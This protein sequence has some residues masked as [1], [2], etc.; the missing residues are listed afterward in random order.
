[1]H[2][3]RRARGP[4][5]DPPGAAPRGALRFIEHGRSPDAKVARRQDQFDPLQG[6]L[7]GGCHLNR[8]IDDLVAGASAIELT[9]LKTYYLKGS[10]TIGYTFEGTATRV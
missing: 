5:R 1:M 3:P 9:G 8:P 6:R 2:D 7:F 4:R 10:R